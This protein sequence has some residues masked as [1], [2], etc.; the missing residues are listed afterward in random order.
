MSSVN[1]MDAALRADDCGLVV[2]DSL[3]NLVPSAEFEAPAED[4]FYCLPNCF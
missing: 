2:L 4:Q 1:I 3:A